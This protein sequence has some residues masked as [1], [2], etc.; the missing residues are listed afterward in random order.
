MGAM[1][2][3]ITSLTIVYSI[4]YWGT[5]QR[6]HQSSASLAFVRGIH[7]GP[8]NSPH[9]GP[10]TRKMFPFD[11]VIM[12]RPHFATSCEILGCLIC[13]FTWA[14][15]HEGLVSPP[16]LCVSD[17]CFIQELYRSSTSVI[18]QM[19]QHNDITKF[20]G[21]DSTFSFSQHLI[22]FN[23]TAQRCPY[24]KVFS[25]SSRSGIQLDNRAHSHE[26]PQLNVILAYNYQVLSWYVTF[27]WQCRHRQYNK[28]GKSFQNSKVNGEG[29]V[30]GKSPVNGL[31]P[32]WIERWLLPGLMS[33]KWKKKWW[34]C[35]IR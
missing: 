13:F 23:L 4:V 6:K 12:T 29:A 25:K 21:H 2:S 1:A 33:F 27:Y 31:A 15:V 19:D 28:I 26:L 24:L 5:D 22:N 14:C 7:R 11:D 30:V 32:R 9:K 8:V 34:A 3:Q 20:L 16:N 35:P 10:V 18:S 17:S